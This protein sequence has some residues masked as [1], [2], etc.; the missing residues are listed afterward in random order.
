[1]IAAEGL[2]ATRHIDGQSRQWAHPLP[3]A[4]SG[5]PFG[6]NRGHSPIEVA[7]QAGEHSAPIPTRRDRAD[8]SAKTVG[9]TSLVVYHTSLSLPVFCRIGERSIQQ[10]LEAFV[11]SK[12]YP[13]AASARE[14][15]NAW[16]VT[17]SSV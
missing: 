8:A 6:W 15:V 2:D 12:I 9:R 3:D 16:A 10:P 11:T 17:L 5:V 1:M 14:A 7:P 4:L 13:D